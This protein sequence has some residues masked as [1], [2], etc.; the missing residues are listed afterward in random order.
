MAALQTWTQFSISVRTIA[1]NRGYGD[2]LGFGGSRT[3]C[4]VTA[5]VPLV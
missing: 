3:H 5:A 2:R 4:R 1:A